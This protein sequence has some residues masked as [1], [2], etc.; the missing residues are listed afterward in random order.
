VSALCLALAAFTA[1][2]NLAGD[3]D[4]EIQFSSSRTDWTPTL[5][6]FANSSGGPQTLLVTGL[7]LTPNEC[8]SLRAGL[9]NKNGV[10]TVTITG[11][12]ASNSPDC[13]GTQGAYNYQFLT[14]PIES[15]GYTVKVI[16]AI[17]GGASTVILETDVAIT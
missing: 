12:Q 15:G 4:P 11:R 9:Q 2:C 3:S 14:A 16:H 5:A 7:M 10:I 13:S 1:N 17:S 8:F 6:A